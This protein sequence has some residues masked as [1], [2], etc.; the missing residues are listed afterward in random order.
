[1]LEPI[2]FDRGGWLNPP[3]KSQITSDR[4]MIETD[5]QTD[6][7]R[8]THYGFTHAN[9]H[10]LLFDMPARFVAE[11]TFSGHFASKY[12]QAGLLLWESE[13]R[14]IKAGIENADGQPN[15]AVVVTEGRSDWSMAPADGG[16]NDWTIRMTATDASVI[17]HAR[18]VGKWQIL[19][20]ANFIA[21]GARIGPMACSPL[22]EGLQA[23]FCNLCTGP[24]P[25]DPLYI[26]D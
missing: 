24:V 2:P 10:A 20:V 19:R 7:W 9:G 14:W 8:E 11:V 4:L 21:D 18:V 13:T 15:L 5:L 22:G 25:E 3:A 12:E 23:T 6:F 17:V 16:V 26:S 1:M